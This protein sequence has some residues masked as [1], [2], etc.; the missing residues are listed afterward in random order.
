MSSFKAKADQATPT[1]SSTS[2]KR[3]DEE[4]PEDTQEWRP[5]LGGHKQSTVFELDTQFMRS[6]LN[7]EMC[8]RGV[9]KLAIAPLITSSMER[10]ALG[11]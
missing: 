4:F 11:G 2:S 7:G 10:C 5:T 9:S 3:A 8:L 6:F 1:K